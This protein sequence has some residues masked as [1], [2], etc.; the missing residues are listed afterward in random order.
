MC[1]VAFAMW[2]QSD[3]E[4]RL[5]QGKNGIRLNG[6]WSRG[7]RLDCV[8][9]REGR[10]AR[11]SGVGCTANEEECEVPAPALQELVGQLY[12][13]IVLGIEGGSRA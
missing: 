6:A 4:L 1:F 9:A 10:Q 8:H 13:V 12:H 3:V 11:P 2:S 5:H 7:P